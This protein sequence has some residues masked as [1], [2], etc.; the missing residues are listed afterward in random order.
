MPCLSPPTQPTKRVV[1]RLSP[2]LRAPEVLVAVLHVVEAVA[3]V[4]V[5]AAVAVLPA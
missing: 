1:N 4:H 2:P 3:V 5:V